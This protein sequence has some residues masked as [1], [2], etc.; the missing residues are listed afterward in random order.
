MASKRSV[1]GYLKEGKARIGAVAI[2]GGRAAKGLC[3]WGLAASPAR[4]GDAQGGD[5]AFSRFPLLALFD[6][7]HTVALSNPSIFDFDFFLS[8]STPKRSYLASRRSDIP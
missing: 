7:K 3:R 2:L 6:P 8:T 4:S 5:D 1:S